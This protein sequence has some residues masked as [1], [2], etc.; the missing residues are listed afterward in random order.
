MEELN[1]RNAIARNMAWSI[2]AV[3]VNSCIK[4][5]ITPYV[6]NNI[7][8]EA[9]GYVALATTFTSYIDIISVSLNAFA[10]RFIS[11]AYHRGDLERANRFYSS[12]II[13]DFMLSVITLIPG[14]VVI[15]CLDSILKVPEVLLSDVRILFGLIFFRY[16]LTVIRTAFD[17]AAFLVNRLD[18]A[19]KRL[20]ISY[21]LQAGTLLL[22]CIIFPPHVWYV[23]ATASVAALYLLI[24]KYRLCRRLTPELTYSRN[25][26]SW[27]AVKEI[28]ATGMWTSLNNLGNVLN[29]GL[30]LLI[31]N[32]MLNAKV[33]GEISVA[34]NLVLLCHTIIMKISDAFQPRLLLLYAENRRDELIGLYRMAIRFTGAV[35]SLIIG[36]FFVCGY[37]F[38][39]LWLPGQN[40]DFLFKASMIVFMG[41][42]IPA[43]MKPLYYSYTLT[44]KVK[45]PC[46][47]TI[48][49]GMTN[50]VSM[51]FLIR[52][53]DLGAY[54][55]ILTTLV[56]NMIHFIDTP[57]YS[58]YCLGVPFKTFYS[59][60]LRH[61]AGAGAILLLAGILRYI[62]PRSE[63]WMGLAV[64]GS[65]SA[66]VLAAFLVTVLFSA[67]ELRTILQGG[68]K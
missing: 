57:L 4:L 31:T 18:L 3:I 28:V 6:S 44:K 48:L 67:A 41:D 64:K 1:S 65:V 16:L 21:L 33:L 58:A 43:A 13:A 50:V 5:F 12:T 22:V 62:L 25:A 60:I 36:T 20:S 30:D 23:G 52:F 2:L 61:I 45:V 46:M 7:G 59:A 17:T 14:T 15:V 8:V 34:K 40:I 54:A 55:V 29:G 9:Y 56:I 47:I 37:D 32:L 42:V 49:M 26:C 19:E 35:C 63:S 38:L 68:K 51:Y 66:I 53:T 24:S 10:G 39:A 11:I 27:K